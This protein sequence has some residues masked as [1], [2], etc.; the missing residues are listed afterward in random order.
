NA[1]GLQV[2]SAVLA[3]IVWMLENP[4]AGLL[5]TDEIDFRR[6]LEIQRPYLGPVVGVYTDWTPLTYRPGLFPEEIDS[7]DPWHFSNVIV[8]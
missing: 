5:D 2:S 6:C 7:S 3:G 8:R 1:T 4:D